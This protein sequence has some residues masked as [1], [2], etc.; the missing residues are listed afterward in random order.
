MEMTRQQYEQKVNE[1]YDW[2]KMKYPTTTKRNSKQE[3]GLN[4]QL[5]P[6]K[7]VEKHPKIGTNVYEK[8]I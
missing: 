1:L 3:N 8:H 5:K 4:G 2:V 6:A 7:K